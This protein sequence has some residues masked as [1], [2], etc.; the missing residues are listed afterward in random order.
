M[1]SFKRFV[2]EAIEVPAK[3]NTK[4][5]D[6]KDMPQIDGKHHKDFLSYL[7]SRG[8]SHKQKTV[9]PETLKATQHQ[10]HKGKIQSLVDYINSGKYDNKP[11]LVSSDNRVM[12]GHHRWLAHKN[13]GN[14]IEV[15]HIDVASKDLLNMMHDYPKSY[16]EKLYNKETK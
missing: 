15:Y 9:D 14:K 5:I 12:D 7:K 8:V 4:S 3:S 13:T 6:R 1:I 11:I 2:A 16:T 10:F